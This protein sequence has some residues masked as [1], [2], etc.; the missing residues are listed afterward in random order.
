[1]FCIF[2]TIAKDKI[3]FVFSDL[4]ITKNS[5]TRA[6]IGKVFL[7]IKIGPGFMVS[8]VYSLIKSG[9]DIKRKIDDRN[10]DMNL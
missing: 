2:D 10:N 5:K 6:S 7:M 9:D 4:I 1:M 8:V 3:Y